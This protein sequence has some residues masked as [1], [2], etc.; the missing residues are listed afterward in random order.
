MNTESITPAGTDDV[1]SRISQ[2]LAPTPQEEDT[3]VTEEETQLEEN[4]LEAEYEDDQI[5]ADSVE[6]PGFGS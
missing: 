3:L 2:I 6:P 4:E 1:T 5:E